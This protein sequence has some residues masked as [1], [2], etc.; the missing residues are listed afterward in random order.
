MLDGGDGAY[1][2][3]LDEKPEA[4]EQDGGDEGDS[5]EEEEKE[6]RTDAVAGIG[7]EEGSHDGGN[8]AAGAEAGDGGAGGGGDLRE[9]G[10]EASQEIEHGEAP[11]VHGVFHRRTEG[12]EEDH[13][14]KDVRPA[15]V[16]KHG[17]EEGGDGVA[18]EDVGG[19]GGPL[20]DEVVSALQLQEE[21]EDVD[22]DDDGGN[23]GI[24]H[25]APRCVS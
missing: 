11:V 16:E 1:V 20:L 5:N 14:A 9:R 23:D 15:G 3:Q 6:Q 2:E 17:G 8:R 12:P 24:V 7:D 13:V 22:D 10:D 4:D 18:G 21:D 25:P 19:D